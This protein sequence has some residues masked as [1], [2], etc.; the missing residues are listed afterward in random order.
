MNF[1]YVLYCENVFF[2]V[3]RAD[4]LLIFRRHIL[5]HMQVL[6]CI[7]LKGYVFR[8]SYIK[9]VHLVGLFT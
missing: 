3:F 7:M 2:Y 1:L 9:K 5:L 8:V 6:V 4:K